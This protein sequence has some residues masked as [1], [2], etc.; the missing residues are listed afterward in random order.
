MDK[1]YL[2][3]STENASPEQAKNP[4]TGVDNSAQQEKMRQAK[5]VANYRQA[6]GDALGSRLYEA[7]SDLLT[8]DQMVRYGKD[9]ADSL[10]DAAVKAASEK[11]GMNLT[12]AAQ[13]QV[14]GGLEALLD[15]VVEKMIRSE[16]GEKLVQK[17]QHG[18]GSNPYA[19]AAVGI[20]VAAG[21]FLTDADIPT[22]KQSIK[23][24]GGFE[25][26][27]SVDLGSLRNIAL[28]ASKI[29]ISYKR[30]DVR[31]GVA[32]SRAKDGQLGGEV[33]GRVGD[34]KQYIQGKV[35]ISE[36]G[37]TA[38]EIGGALGLGD[39]T[40][41]SGKATGTELDKIPD[42][43]VQVSTEHGDFKHT[44]DLRYSSSSKDLFA[45]YTGQKESL[46]YYASLSGNVKSDSLNQFKAGARY[47]PDKGDVYSADYQYNFA[48]QSHQLDMVA[49]ER[50][51]DFS[52]RGH[53]QFKYNEQDQLKSNTELMAAYH[54]GTDLSLIGG[55]DI[56]HDFQTGQTVMAPK[57]GI[58]YKDVPI[59]LSYDPQ[60][61][62]TSVGI[63]LK[64]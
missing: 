14:V 23:L 47:T 7:V 58:Q 43:N 34:D 33:S 8:M 37:I 35:G 25:A 39:K 42:W 26:N 31:A 40:N 11:S 38:F 6:L 46:V 53:Q 52:L 22:L 45:K 61:K 30:K 36:D 50:M 48:N 15:P 9:L 62:S 21:A 55:A 10:L 49:Q 63:T 24:G 19:V 27:G 1:Q 56:K 13:E 17:L 28:G 29:G 4:S 59:V 41:L 18:V 32:I 44:G 3:K 57:A 2:D 54:M 51:G 5:Y 64:F 12:N 16:T 60:T 20:L